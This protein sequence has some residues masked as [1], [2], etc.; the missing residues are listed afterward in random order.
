MRRCALYNPSTGSA[1]AQRH[2]D[3]LLAGM[4]PALSLV[5]GQD[6]VESFTR[7]INGKTKGKTKG[8]RLRKLILT[9]DST[10][11]RCLAWPASCVSNS[12]ARATM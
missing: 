2:R 12:P 1:F 3:T 6:A 10:G 9:A 4:I 11:P 7:R 8:V 5:T